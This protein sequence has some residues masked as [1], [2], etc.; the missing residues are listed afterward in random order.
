MGGGFSGQRESHAAQRPGYAGAYA[1]DRG[2]TLDVYNVETTPRVFISF[3]VEDEAQVNLLRHQA[4]NSD[5]LEFTDYSVKEPFDEAWKTQCT[6]RIRQSSVVVV[7]IGKD[8]HARPAVLWE[9]EKAH[10]L[11]KPVIGMRIYGDKN[12]KVPEP[13]QRHG[14]T[15]TAWDLEE[16]QKE[17]DKKTKKRGSDERREGNVT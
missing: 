1:R 17:I 6:E 5:K 7:A 11:G 2:P 13:M 3:H 4:K 15:V 9:I 16:L 10:E 8:T 12:H 14:D